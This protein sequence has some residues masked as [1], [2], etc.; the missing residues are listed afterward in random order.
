MLATSSLGSKK[1]NVTA[2]KSGTAYILI[3]KDDKVVGSVAI[4]IGAE[5]T[6]ATLELDKYSVTVSRS[7]TGE[8]KGCK[9]NC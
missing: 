5:R 6:V 7:L 3:K 1:V 9:G 2:L 4:E 8:C